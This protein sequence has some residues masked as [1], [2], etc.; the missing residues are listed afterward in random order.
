MKAL[1]VNKTRCFVAHDTEELHSIALRLLNER[2]TTEPDEKLRSLLD[3]VT[4]EQDGDT[5]ISLVDT[6]FDVEVWP[7]EVI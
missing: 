7:V 6:I 1:I 2:R 4:D 5:A 3:V